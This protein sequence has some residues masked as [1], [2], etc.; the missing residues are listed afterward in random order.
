MAGPVRPWTLPGPAALVARVCATADRHKAAV[1]HAPFDAAAL[2]DALQDHLARQG[3]FTVCRLD[4]IGTL[5]FE[6]QLAGVAHV[7]CTNPAALATSPTLDQTA[8]VVRTRGGALAGLATF[9]RMIRRQPP[10]EGP[11]LIVVSED[12]ACA[13]EGC[14]VEPVRN[15]FGPLDGAAYAATLPT[16]LR[17]F[18]ARLVASVAIEVAAW[19]VVLLERLMALPPEQAIRPDRHVCSWD[20][21]DMARWKGVTLAWANGSVDEWGGEQMEHPLWL[22]ANRPEGLSKRVWRG[23]LAILLPWIEQNRQLIIARERRYLR[24]DKVRSGPDLESLDW[25]PL[26]FQLSRVPAVRS[27][28]QTLRE[29]RNELAHGRPITCDHVRRC[30]AAARAYLA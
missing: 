20:D 24:V 4:L 14:S 15:A 22:A 13:L 23:Q 16:G 8:L 19:N 26:A 1:L 11:I 2:A 12:G 7:G 6:V 25:G 17:P 30:I 27:L 3:T 29:A 9:A 18:E 21:G 10:G 28:A 5:P